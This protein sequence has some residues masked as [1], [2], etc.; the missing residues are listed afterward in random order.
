MLM[1]YGIVEY[2][3]GSVVISRSTELDDDDFPFI[4]MPLHPEIDQDDP[5]QAA[6]LERLL[7]DVVASGAYT[8]YEWIP[9]DD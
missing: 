9:E 2:A 7:Q 4:A 1:Y 5:E 3:R 8:E 6:L